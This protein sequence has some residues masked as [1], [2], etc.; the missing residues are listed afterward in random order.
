MKILHI[1]QYCHL[2]SI[3]GTERYVLDLIRELDVLHVESAIGWVT[4]QSKENAHLESFQVFL[5]PGVPMR[6]DGPHPELRLIFASVIADFQPSIIHFHTFGRSEAA[7]ARC[8]SL[9][10]I[11]YVFTYH[12]PAWT[13]RREDLMAFNRASLCD[14]EVRIFRCAA[15][16]MHE[17]LEFAPV[18]LAWALVFLTLPLCIMLAFF[19]QTGFRRKVAFLADTW[20]FRS[21]LRQFLKKCSRVFACAEWSIPVLTANGTSME[22]IAKCPQGVSQELP[23]SEIP[24]SRPRKQ[25]EFTIGYVGRVVPVKGV[26]ILVEGFSKLSFNNVKLHIYGW[27]EN[28]PKDAF[29][30]CIAEAA[31][32][33][34]RIHLLPKFDLPEMAKIYQKID[35]LCIPSVWPETGPLVLFEALQRGIPVYGSS[36]VGQLGLLQERGRVVEPN[37]VE[38]WH[39]ALDAALRKHGH[40]EWDDVCEKAKGKGKLRAMND[41]AEE[42]NKAYS[43]ILSV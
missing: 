17:R 2:G 13:C 11:P 22:Q 30:H 6:V 27:P 3:G 14:G 31:K 12:S 24:R 42:I 5:L 8:A 43:S 32:K 15:C 23:L 33:D 38:Q 41:V 34:R 21:E 40:G 20:M 4:L 39:I 25:E 37:T 18:W 36:R 10:G 9:Q 1:T 28:A 26:D 29:Y 35:L 19:P 7:V 16:K